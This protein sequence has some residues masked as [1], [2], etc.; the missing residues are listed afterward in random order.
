MSICFSD[1]NNDIDTIDTYLCQDYSFWSN[2]TL[3]WNNTC[4]SDPNSDTYPIVRKCIVHQKENIQIE[5]CKSHLDTCPN[6]TKNEKDCEENGKFFCKMSKS[7]I[8]QTKTCDGIVHCIGAED[9]DF[10]LCHQASKSIFPET[11]TIPCNEIGRGSYNIKILATPCSGECRDENCDQDW[12]ILSVFIGFTF[13]GIAT[14][15][16]YLHF[17]TT[18]RYPT[19]VSDD[20]ENIDEETAEARSNFRGNVLAKIKVITD[21]GLNILCYQFLFI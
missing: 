16:A 8:D 12:R 21:L 18:K 7:C 13:A 20:P 9:E 3:S 1:V 15:C 4:I 5:H 17:R 19:I 6:S 11:A 2:I 10:N 14:M